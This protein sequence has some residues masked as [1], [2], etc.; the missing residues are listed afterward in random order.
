MHI[1]EHFYIQSKKIQQDTYY[2]YVGFSE[3]TSQWP[4]KKSRG[5]EKNVIKKILKDT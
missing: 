3:K 1:V 4:G 2:S 5:A